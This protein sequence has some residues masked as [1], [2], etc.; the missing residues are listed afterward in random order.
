MSS[1]L[2]KI[3][4]YGVKISIE[5]AEAHQKQL[6]LDRLKDVLPINFT[7]LSPG[8]KTKIEFFVKSGKKGKFLLFKGDEKVLSD[9][10]EAMLLERLDS[11]IRLT[12]AEFAVDHVF[13]HSGVVEWKGKAIMIPASSYDGKTT[14]VTE[15]VKKGATYY[16]D[17]YAIL[18]KKGM[19]TPFPKTLSIREEASNGRQVEYP[20]ETFGGKKGVKPLPIGMVLVTKYKKGSHWKPE[21]L[22]RGE[23]VLEII[24]HTVPIRNDP[25]FSLTV[26]N[27]VVENALI[28]KSNRGEASRFVNTLIKFFEER[29]TNS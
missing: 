22:T 12:V 17:E 8:A 7:V 23:G 11:Q 2:V 20:V 26:L 18:N 6:L 9:T 29:V 16:S 3:E 5:V 27:K 19:V 21:V 4:S 13:V 1:K 10:E 25:E 28:V 15:L 14:M 24:S